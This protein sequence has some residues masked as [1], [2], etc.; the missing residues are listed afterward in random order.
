MKS[1]EIQKF[2][3]HHNPFQ[4][5][6]H[7]HSIHSDG[8]KTPD[9][10]VRMAQ[11]LKYSVISICDH[12]T[13]AGYHEAKDTADAL[14]IGL[15]PGI[16]IDVEFNGS[17]YHLM[18]YGFDPNDKK[19]LSILKDKQ[20][21]RKVRAEKLVA[22]LIKNNKF[23]ISMKQI[24]NYGS[25]VIARYHI[26]KAIMESPRNREQVWREV[27]SHPNIFEIINYYMGK[28]SGNYVP[29]DHFTAEEALSMVHNAGGVVTVGHPGA[30]QADCD[31]AFKMDKNLYDLFELGVD[32]LEVY[33]P[34]HLP[35][36]VKHYEEIV[37]KENLIA[38]GGSDYHGVEIPGVRWT[39]FYVPFEV[40]EELEKALIKKDKN[41]S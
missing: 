17:D 10:L 35:I 13:V 20:A 33:S 30:L 11:K 39:D 5:D 21:E 37:K 23:D 9:E 8:G 12:H 27:N 3:E 40:Y 25:K 14:K 15:I 22:N 2:Y 6:L 18:G 38:T 32:G 34:K 41:A 4:V 7:M 31:L 36:E 28:E 16:E 1:L 24:E 19:L 26:V 29:K